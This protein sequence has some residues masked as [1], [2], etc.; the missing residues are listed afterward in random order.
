MYEKASV[1]GKDPVA[2]SCRIIV[3]RKL[4]STT[5]AKREEIRGHLPLSSMIKL[6]IL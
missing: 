5:I 3:D 2:I 6:L 1:Y 4:A